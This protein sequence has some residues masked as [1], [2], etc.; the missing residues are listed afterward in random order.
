MKNKDELVESQSKRRNE[1]PPPQEGV[2]CAACPS[3]TTIGR[4][5]PGPTAARRE[6]EIQIIKESMVEFIRA[7]PLIQCV[8]R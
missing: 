5:Q 8:F 1:N 4:R 7:Q 3:A 2:V 6:A